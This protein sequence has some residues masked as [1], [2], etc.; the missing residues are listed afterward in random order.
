M[1]YAIRLKGNKE[2]R[3]ADIWGKST[4]NRKKNKCKIPEL[5]ACLVCLGNIKEASVAGAKRVM[6]DHGDEVREVLRTRSGR[7]PDVTG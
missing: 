6:G 7:V 4:I 5:G 2:D 1:T 3:H